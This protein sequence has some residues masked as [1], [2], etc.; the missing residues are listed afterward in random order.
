MVISI[1]TLFPEQFNSVF[2]V[3]LIKR[4]QG[5]QLVA[6]H[7]INIRDFASDAYKTVDDHPYGGGT[8]MILRIDILDRAITYA[9][10]QTPSQTTRTILLDPKGKVFRQ[11]TAERLARVDHLILI[12]GHYEGV[13]ERIRELVDEELSIGD[14]I[15][16][17]GEIPAMV[18]VDT[19]VRLLPGVLKKETATQE[20]SFSRG[21]LEYPQYTR[22]VVYRGMNVPSILL[23]GDHKKIAAWKTEEARKTTKKRRPDLFPKE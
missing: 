17:G 19:V 5:K 10:S 2:D 16:S 6:L 7:C 23:S 20:E 22:P 13:D 3:S 1:L 21:G 9:K 11:S 15:L 4:A 18:V 8:G 12:C 14:I